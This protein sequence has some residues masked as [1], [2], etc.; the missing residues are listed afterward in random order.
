MTFLDL[1]ILL[2]QIKA[3]NL[4]PIAVGSPQRA[5][6]AKDVPTTAEVGMP[7]VLAENW[8]GMVAPGATPPAIIAAL[9][10]IATEAMRD[11]AVKEKLATQGADL[12]GDTPEQFRTFIASETAKWAKVIKDAG[13]QTEK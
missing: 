8:Y 12:I 10:K 2:P 1:P 11:P 9:N 3:G 6:T 13:I 7:E 5:A 4:K